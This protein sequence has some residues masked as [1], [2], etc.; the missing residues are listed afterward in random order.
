[1]MGADE[2]LEIQVMTATPH[3]LHLMVVD[4]AI[5]FAKQAEAAFADEDFE[6]SH[7][8]LNRAREFVNELIG[9]LNPD[10]A[11]ELVNRLKGLF[12]FVSQNLVRADLERDPQLVRDALKILGMHR[13]T[14]SELG[15]AL[16][17]EQQQASTGSQGEG[18]SGP[19]EPHLPGNSWVS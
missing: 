1:M 6:T 13:E 19:R 12:G 15:A 14:W 18:N 4:G 8:S 11:E 7:F 10:H 2:Y 16:S 3:Q 9:G 17:A 5:R